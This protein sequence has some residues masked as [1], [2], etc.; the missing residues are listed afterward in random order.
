MGIRKNSTFW[1]YFLIWEKNTACSYTS[2]NDTSNMG[3]TDDAREKK[4]IITRAESLDR[5]K[6]I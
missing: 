1:F 6:E 2:R 3:M 4:R 5:K